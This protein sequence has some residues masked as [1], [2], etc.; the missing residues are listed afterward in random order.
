MTKKF[1]DNLKPGDIIVLDGIHREWARWA[2]AEVESS[3]IRFV[4]L[5]DIS[6]SEWLGK[7]RSFAKCELG[8]DSEYAEPSG[9]NWRLVR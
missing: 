2:V 3:I 5:H 8:Q 7:L 1:I 6:N 9:P 4:V